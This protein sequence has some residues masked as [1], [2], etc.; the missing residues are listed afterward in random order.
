[1]ARNEKA[2]QKKE[3]EYDWLEDPFNEEKAAQE[4]ERAQSA[5]RRGCIVAVIV[6][7]AA[8]IVLFVIG[9]ILF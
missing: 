3:Q 9:F 5:Q 4:L 6:V 8:L 1:M 7:L 2:S